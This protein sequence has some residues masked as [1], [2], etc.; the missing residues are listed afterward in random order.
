MKPPRKVFKTTLLLL[1]LSHSLASVPYESQPGA[2]SSHG[3]NCVGC[4][5]VI[6]LIE[7]LAEV[8]NSSVQVAMERLCSYLPEKLFLKTSCYF[9]VQTFGSDIIKLLGEAM[10][11]DVV[12][13]ALEFCKQDAV[14]SQCHLYPLPQEAW[15][16]S[17][18]KARQVLRRPSTVKYSR[19][20]HNICS[21]PFFTKICQKI[22][23][24]MKKAVP[25]N[26]G[27]SDKYSVFPTLR[28]Y[29]WRGRDCNDKDKT[30]Y[31]GRRPDNWDIHQDSNCNGIWGIDPKDGIPYEKKFCEGSQ[32]KGIILLGDSAGAHFHIPPEWLTASQMSVKSFSNLPS[33]L[34]DELNWPQL[35]GVTGF[36]DSTSGIE[37]KSIYYRLRKRNHCNHRDYQSISKNGASSRNLKNFIES[38]SRNQA[39]DHPAIVIYAM[40][41]NDVCNGRA[42]TIPGMTTPEQMYA[43]VMQTL[44]HLNS[45]LPNGSH[46]ILYGLPDGTFLW[47]SLHNRYHPLGQLNKDVTYAQFFSFLSCLQVSPCNGWMSS[48]KTLR[49]LTSERAEQLSNILKKIATTKTF[50]NFDLFYMDFAFHEIIEDWQKRGGQPWQLIE[51]VDGFHPNEVAS[52]LLAN[53]VWKKIQL[54]W[55]HVLGKENPF[56]SQIEEVFGDQG[57][58]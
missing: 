49:A 4:V 6:S 10:K 15:K 48:N 54:Q 26:D 16:S 22:E 12:C 8:H 28:G 11:A 50:A 34:T 27:D 51:P 23:L 56:N 52:L 38:L 47:D 21:L 19:S 58:H 55:P 45:H 3:P 44:K 33:A 31:P 40:I 53:R 35:S 1:L 37:E 2:S 25:F 17:L 5:V 9:L 13:Y 39:L 7:Q 43:N 24:S 57:G 29:H 42:D 18:E 46:V 20:G 36:L 41:G 30:V 32:P 14:Q